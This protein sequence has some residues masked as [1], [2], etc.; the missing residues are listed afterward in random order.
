M[1]AEL[2]GL[3]KKAIE[4]AIKANMRYE[5]SIVLKAFM[6]DAQNKTDPLNI[7]NEQ[8]VL[9]PII[10]NIKVVHQRGSKQV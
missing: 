4:H 2:F 7:S 8:E 6:A 5:L 1:Y 3:C 9:N 10:H